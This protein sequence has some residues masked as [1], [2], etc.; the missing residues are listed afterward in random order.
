MRWV[1]DYLHRSSFHDGQGTLNQAEIGW[2]WAVADAEKLGMSLQ[3]GLDH[4]G[5]NPN[6]GASVTYAYSL[7]Y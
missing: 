5:D 7:T 1:S 2:E 3:V 6:F 4:T